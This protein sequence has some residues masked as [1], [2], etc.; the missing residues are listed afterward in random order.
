MT[1]R[2]LFRLAGLALIL[3]GVLTPLAQIIHPSDERP[4]TILAQTGRLVTG[5]VLSTVAILLGLLGLVGLYLYESEET[6]ILGLAGFILA[7]TGNVLLTTSGNFGYIAPVLA[8]H[9]PD[10]LAAANTYPPELIL[11]VVMVL[12]YIIG[13]LLLG[14]ATVRARRL[15]RLSGWLLAASPPV[16]LI[17]SGI[18]LA[19]GLTA[20]YWFGI[21]GQVLFGIG[22]VLAGR[23]L[24]SQN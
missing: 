20:F 11:D 6:G 16:F 18:S 8:S 9:A 15:P 3:C 24:W 10:T 13:F 22:L 4:Q 5:H 7:F 23:V 1:T 21:L 19:S 12:S 17:F 2:K 14:M